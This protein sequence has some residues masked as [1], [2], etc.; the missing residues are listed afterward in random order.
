MSNQ[1]RILC[2]AIFTIISVSGNAWASMV[3]SDQ[4]LSHLSTTNSD[5]VR[6][7]SQYK[8]SVQALIPIYENNLKTA[9]EAL[10]KR[11]ELLTQGLVSKRDIDRVSMIESQTVMSRRLT[12]RAD[13]KFPAELRCEEAFHL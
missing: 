9:M 8:A 7:A 5:L 11:K 12:E 6:A 4:A 3:N 13:R 10:V 1:L 2:C